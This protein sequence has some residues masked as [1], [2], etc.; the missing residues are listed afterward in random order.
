MS[1]PVPAK[2]FSLVETLVVA[3]I[4]A[5]IGALSLPALRASKE[6]SRVGASISK[7]KQWHAANVLYCQEVGCEPKLVVEVPCSLSNAGFH[8]KFPMEMFRTGGS[9]RSGKPGEDVYT[10][11]PG[12]A[13]SSEVG[14]QDWLRRLAASNGNPV[15]VLDETQNAGAGSAVEFFRLRRVIGLRY[16]GSVQTRWAKGVLSRNEIFET[17]KPPSEPP[18][19]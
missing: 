8:Y 9:S 15:Y 1:G 19:H 5:L 2:G 13:C 18:S 11:I 4:I 6:Q 10:Y 12:S 3:A 7:L 16:D 14:L 17:E